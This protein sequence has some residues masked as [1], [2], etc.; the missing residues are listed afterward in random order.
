[1]MLLR[2]KVDVDGEL[3]E[4][5][6]AFETHGSI[7]MAKTV[8]YNGRLLSFVLAPC[9]MDATHELSAFCRLVLPENTIPAEI[10]IL[11]AVHCYLDG[12]IGVSWLKDER[13][14]KRL[15][16]VREFRSQFDLN[17]S[18]SPEGS[19]EAL[20][21]VQEG[22]LLHYVSNARTATLPI[23]DAQLALRYG[24]S[25]YERYKQCQHPGVMFTTHRS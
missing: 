2:V 15:A 3:R 14:V 20:M 9:L 6:A 25:R 22:P 4:V 23:E 12:K 21:V 17:A 18:C 19:P 5:D 7:C 11:S 16:S 8:R 10:V 24:N 13:F 1:M